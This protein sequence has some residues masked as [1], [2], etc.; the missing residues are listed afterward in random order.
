M[1]ELC[2]QSDRGIL[3]YYFLNAQNFW[4]ARWNFAFLKRNWEKNNN[5][6]IKNIKCRHYFNLHM[7]MIMN[8]WHMIKLKVAKSSYVIG[9]I[10]GK[11]LI[12]NLVPILKLAV[13]G[14]ILSKKMIS[15][16]PTR[17]WKTFFQDFTRYCM[18]YTVC[19]NFICV[20][21]IVLLKDKNRANIYPI[22]IAPFIME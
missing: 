9:C 12:W 15:I 20:L 8:L 18:Y 10:I 4:R 1:L 7:D 6:A 2:I 16:L 11:K 14:K 21:Y 13:A 22:S 17:N 3:Y 5:F 19:Q